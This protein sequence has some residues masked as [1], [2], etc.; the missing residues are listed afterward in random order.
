MHIVSV[1]RKIAQKNFQKILKGVQGALKNLNFR[2]KMTPS[3]KSINRLPI[4]LNLSELVFY[5]PVD[6]TDSE[7]RKKNFFKKY[8]GG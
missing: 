6:H 5:K 2:V 1:N 7:S 4:H 8:L 3:L